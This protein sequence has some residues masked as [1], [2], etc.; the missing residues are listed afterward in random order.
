MN[1]IQLGDITLHYRID[2][3]PDGVP[4]VFGNSLGTDLRLWDQVLAHLPGGFRILRFDKRGHGLSS[5][6][7]GDYRI[8][9]QPDA[10]IKTMPTH[11]DVKIPAE[12]E[13]VASGRW[14]ETPGPKTLL[15][16]TFDGD[17]STYTVVDETTTNGPSAWLASGA[18]TI[19]SAR[20]KVTA[21]SKH[22]SCW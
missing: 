10:S 9:F 11:I 19:P 21:A 1:M 3:D 22:S 6:P 2:G 12:A 5:C 4:I 18:G 8:S 7:P 14:R 17:L 16:D 20:A 15:A 13:V